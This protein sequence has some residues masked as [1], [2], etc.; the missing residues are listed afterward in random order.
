MT[1]NRKKRL[2]WQVPFLVLLIVGTIL[3]IRQQQNMP[4]QRC[5]GP[6]FGTIYNITYQYNEDLQKELV[7]KMN[8]VDR[9][10]SMFNENSVISHIN[11]GKHYIPKTTEGDMFLEVYNLAMQISEET[12]GAFDITIAPLVNAWGFG[13]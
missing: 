8:E 4:Y 7:E 11:Q 5:S 12:Q 9:A 2:M 1:E 13:F 10:L 6:I 3:I